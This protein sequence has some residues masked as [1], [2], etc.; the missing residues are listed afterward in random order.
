M[1][2]S[3]YCWLTAFILVIANGKPF[4]MQ[5]SKLAVREL[6]CIHSMYIV[7]Y[8]GAFN[9]PLYNPM[10]FSKA[11]SLPFI[12]QLHAL[13]KSHH[14]AASSNVKWCI[15]SSYHSPQRHW[16]TLQIT[17]QNQKTK[18]IGKAKKQFLIQKIVIFL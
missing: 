9:V 7:V 1:Q 2:S 10:M 4:S 3:W 6:F 15:F 11:A 5:K 16:Q 12:R 14:R 8:S 17:K 18:K 13:L